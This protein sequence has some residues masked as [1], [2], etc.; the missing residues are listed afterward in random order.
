MKFWS[1]ALDRI[2]M[3]TRR[4]MELWKNCVENPH[5]NR[6]VGQNEKYAGGRMRD[7]QRGAGKQILE[8]I[9]CSFPHSPHRSKPN[10]TLSS[11]SAK[12]TNNGDPG[13]E[14][15]RRQILRTFHLRKEV[16]AGTIRTKVQWQSDELMPHRLFCICPNVCFDKTAL[17][18]NYNSNYSEL[19]HTSL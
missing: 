3:R 13:W 6:G 1:R 10:P 2:N 4:S 15:K 11:S 14:K 7:W 18:C 9:C 12:T 8:S 5:W 17:H 19:A 16:A